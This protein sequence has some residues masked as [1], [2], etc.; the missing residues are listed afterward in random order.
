MALVSSCEMCDSYRVVHAERRAQVPGGRPDALARDSVSA[1]AAE[2]GADGSEM[3]HAVCAC[4]RRDGENVSERT[5]CLT[6]AQLKMTSILLLPLLDEV[7][8]DEV[9]SNKAAY[10]A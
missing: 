9:S 10:R 7:N 2:A 8:I 5:A 3:R 6:S 4:S 1:G